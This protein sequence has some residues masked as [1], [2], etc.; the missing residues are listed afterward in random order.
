MNSP[1]C[2][3]MAP[4]NPRPRG[5]MLA[6]E[7][8]DRTKIEAFNDLYS[9]RIRYDHPVTPDGQ[10]LANALI[11]AAKQEGRGRVVLLADARLRAGCESAGLIHE[12]TIPGFYNG[13][14]HCAVMG[15][16]IDPHRA[17]SATPAEVT[18]V[19]DLVSAKTE[20]VSSKRAPVATERATVQD[21]ASIAALINRTFTFY[22]TPSGVPEY[23]ATQIEDGIPFRVVRKNSQVVACA[24]ADLV[25][26]AQT[27]E[28]T[29]C[30]THPSYRGHGYMQAILA[31]LMDDLRAMNYP[32]VFTL[33]R[34]CQAGVNIG[35]KRL[36][37]LFRGRMKQSCRIGDSI[38]DINVWSR[39]L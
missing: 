14:S 39:A 15:K 16:A 8:P 29:D 5:K 13:Q 9:D 10:A 31:D 20:P 4:D 19:D 30:A 22:P 2:C 21:A 32:T 27:A 7:L 38:E 12:A 6:I 35:F 24:S 37:F 23:I 25:R 36:G 34:A 3:L 18:K 33:A 11:S 1:A 26:G 28:L 17:G